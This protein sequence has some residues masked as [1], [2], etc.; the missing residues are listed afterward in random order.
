MN[1]HRRTQSTITLSAVISLAI[2]AGCGGGG[3]SSGSS[4]NVTP[5]GQTLSASQQA[6]ESVALAA[7]GGTYRVRWNLEQAAAQVSGT[8]YIYSEFDSLAA[9]PLTAGTQQATESAPVNLST[10]LALVTA[11]PTRVLKGGAVRVVPSTQYSVAVRYSGSDVVVDSLDSNGAVAY[12]DQRSAITFTALSGNLSAAPQEFK[13]SYNSL[14]ANANLLKASAIWGS[15]AGYLKYTSKAVGDR[16]MAFDCFATTTGADVSPCQTSTTLTAALTSGMTS[17]S[18]GTTYHLADGT[19]QTVDGV[20][21]WV[22]TAARPQSAVNSATTQ[23]RIYY[24]LNGNVYTGALIK[25]GTTLGGNVYTDPLGAKSYL[26][27][28]IR[29]NKAAGDSIA[30][31]VAF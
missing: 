10:T 1:L 24:Q 30:A 28:L 29:L 15:G 18:D 3:D 8:N 31:G 26:N 14:F 25:D 9:S 20:S 17:N 22:A 13:Q 2:L 16:Y 11:A 7:N 23:Y 27:Y 6:F 21:V 5:A 4:T 19:V 12:S